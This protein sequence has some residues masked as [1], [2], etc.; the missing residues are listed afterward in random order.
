MTHWTRLY[1]LKAAFRIDE[2]IG[3]ELSNGQAI[4]WGIE[5]TGYEGV[6]HV[7]AEIRSVHDQ[8]QDLVRAVADQKFEEVDDFTDSLAR[9]VE[10]LCD[11]SSL[12][13]YDS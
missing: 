1:D 11:L 8:G 5:I 4:D 13:K 10:D 7:E 2:S 3:A 6:L 12:P 9:I